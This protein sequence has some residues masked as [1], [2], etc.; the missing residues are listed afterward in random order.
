MKK[1]ASVLKLI[2]SLIPAAAM[3]MGKASASRACSFW[4]YQPRVPK[5]LKK[6]R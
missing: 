4:F 2:G 1:T 6:S 5:A 3:A